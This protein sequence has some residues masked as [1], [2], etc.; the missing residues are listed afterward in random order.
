[1]PRLTE[2]STRAPKEFEKEATKESTKILLKRFGELQPMLFAEAKW[3]LLIVLQGMDASG[4][5]GVVKAVFTGVNPMGCQVHAFKKPTEEEFSHDFLWRV[6]KYTP[7]KGMIQIFNR[8]H[9]EDILV[10][11]V[12]KSIDKALIK[13]R[14]DH[15]ND[16]EKLLEEHN[17]LVFKFYLHISKEEQSE[18]LE[19]RVTDKEKQWKYRDQDLEEAKKW[20]M[21]METYENI[22]SKCNAIPWHIVPSDQNWYKE[23][24]IART[25]VEKLE[26]LGLK[27]PGFVEE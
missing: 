12:H 22:F 13:N 25:V 2:I 6:H 26:T 18:R 27:Y 1:M 15:I 21:Y 3:S 24:Y 17:T 11:T 9:Y 19:E 14:Y 7:P 8:S 20:D 4:K 5:D 10:P 16:F 23:H